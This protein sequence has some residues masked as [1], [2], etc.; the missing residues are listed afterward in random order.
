MQHSWYDNVW[1]RADADGENKIGKWLGPAVGIGGGDCYWILPLSARRIA[2]ST[3]WAITEEEF[4]VGAIKDSVKA[5]DI[6]ITERIGDQLD[7]N[8]GVGDPLPANG[9]YFDDDEDDEF[10]DAVD[11]PEAEHYTPETFDGYLTASVMLPRGVR[12]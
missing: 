10:E 2:R 4:T 5:L 1:Y 11:R 12:F 3:V 8:A 7:N 9:D 6:S